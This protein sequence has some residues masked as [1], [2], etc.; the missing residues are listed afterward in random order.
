MKT[1]FFLLA[2]L[3]VASLFAVTNA[4]G[5]IKW[6]LCPNRPKQT[7]AINNIIMNPNPPVSGQNFNVQIQGVL[8]TPV[9]Q[10]SLGHVTVNYAGA[11]LYDGDF[12]PCTI[13]TQSVNCPIQAGNVNLNIN[14]VI[15]PFAP[16]G[17]PY[18]GQLA[19]IDEHSNLVFCVTFT[20]YMN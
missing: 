13:D 14:D 16:A 17:G 9:G 19:V 12:D 7:L 15:P 3:L 10:G 4:Q 6:Q 11:P 8:S 5:P 20:F 2:F 1:T 18:D